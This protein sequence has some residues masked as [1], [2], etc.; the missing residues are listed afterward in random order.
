MR[1]ESNL[2]VN[3]HRL[4]KLCTGFDVE[5][6]IQIL[7]GLQC[8]FYDLYKR[9]VVPS[10]ISHFV[11]L[12]CMTESW[13]PT[14]NTLPDDASLL[15]WYLH[16]EQSTTALKARTHVR[17]LASLPTFITHLH[18]IGNY[19]SCKATRITPSK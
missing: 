4:P 15:S 7:I 12:L 14:I 19:S 2:R 11:R 18:C 9:A 17:R 16:I 1:Y 10:L 13:I 5:R 6:E 8:L 3:F